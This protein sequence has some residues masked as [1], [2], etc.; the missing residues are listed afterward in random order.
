MP[1][2]KK[3]PAKKNYLNE[4]TI[5]LIVLMLLSAVITNLTSQ[6]HLFQWYGLQSTWTS[7]LGWAKFSWSL[8]HIIAAFLSA[9]AIVWAYYSGVKLRQLEIEE[10]K[11]FRG[12]SVKTEEGIAGVTPLARKE[13]EKWEHVITLANSLNPSDWRLA[14]IEAD[15]M[16]DE[17][18]RSKGYRG[19]VGEMLKSVPSGELQTIDNA[20]E[21]HKVRNR[22]AHSGSSFELNEREMKRVISLFESVFKEGKWI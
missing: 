6:Y 7:A 5:F 9:G 22:I 18:L 14:I 2:D 15:V 11:I 10:A 3:A 21:A 1:P 17:F 19:E 4:V 16:L 20:W 13:G 12:K 8:L